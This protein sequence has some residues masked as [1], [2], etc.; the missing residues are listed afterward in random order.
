MILLWKVKTERRSRFALGHTAS[1]WWNQYSRLGL[2]SAR[3]FHQRFTASPCIA[4]CVCVL[5]RARLFAAHGLWPFRLLWPWDSPGKNTGVGGQALLQGIFPTRGSNSH[6]LRLLYWQ[7]DSLP[8]HHPGSLPC[9]IRF[10]HLTT[11]AVSIWV[12]KIRIHP[13]LDW[14]SSE[15]LCFGWMQQLRSHRY[16]VAKLIPVFRTLNSCTHDKLLQSC[17]T[18]YNPMDQSPSGSS[19]H[20]ILQARILEWAAMPSSRG[21]SW[22]RDQTHVS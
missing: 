11:L 6:L 13:L 21:S 9:I 12:N 18:L 20:G 14:L 22:P 1:A 3:A 4:V 7:A 15:D 19:V 2:P 10:C 16:L 8:L 5:S 17:L